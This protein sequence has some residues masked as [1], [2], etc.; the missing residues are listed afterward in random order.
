[1]SGF[2]KVYPTHAVVDSMGKMLSHG[3]RP[4]CISFVANES[5]KAY[6]NMATL[7]IVSFSS[8]NILF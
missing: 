8:L 5:L 2:P 1:M 4:E 6:G 7:R 3:S